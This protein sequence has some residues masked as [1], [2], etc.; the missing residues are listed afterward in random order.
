MKV[1][2]SKILALFFVV[3]AILQAQTITANQESKLN[4]NEATLEELMSIPGIGMAKASA[5]ISYRD[6]IGGFTHYDQLLLVSGIGKKLAA[7][8]QERTFLGDYHKAE[9][10]AQAHQQPQQQIG[11]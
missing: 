2:F 5:I 4:L 8:V 6:S 9:S 11:K 1:H 3:T 10:E 7:T